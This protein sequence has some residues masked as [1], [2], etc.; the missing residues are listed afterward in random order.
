MSIGSLV[1]LKIILDLAFADAY[2]QGVPF[3][4]ATNWHL[5]IVQRGQQIL[6]NRVLGFQV[7]NEPDLYI[8]HGRRKEVSQVVKVPPV[9]ARFTRT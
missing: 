1:C 3:D 8:S 6:G 4:D 7:G 5:D 9:G 2:S